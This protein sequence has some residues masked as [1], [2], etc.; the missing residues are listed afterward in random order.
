MVCLVCITRKKIKIK[1]FINSFF[2][3]VNIAVK[4]TYKLSMG[5]KECFY[6]LSAIRTTIILY[7]T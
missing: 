1:R 5:E 6:F 3:L 7:Q 4:S 2:V